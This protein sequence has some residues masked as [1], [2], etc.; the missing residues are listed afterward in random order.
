[1]CSDTG[2]NKM[3]PA[4]LPATVDGAEDKRAA[5]VLRGSSAQ[6]AWH[7]QHHSSSMM[8]HVGSSS[9]AEHS[10]VVESDATA[11]WPSD[12]ELRDASHICDALQQS[13]ITQYARGITDGRTGM[14]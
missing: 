6:R 4:K 14:L 2:F 1:M 10:R 12:V 8:C 11:I 3:F 7:V 9:A 5:I 13:S